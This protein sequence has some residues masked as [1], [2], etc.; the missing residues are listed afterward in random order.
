[1][2]RVIAAAG[3]LL[4]VAA[5][6]ASCGGASLRSTALKDARQY[7][8]ASNAQV[9]SLETVQLEGGARHAVAR[10]RGRFH[11]VP[12]CPAPVGNF[13]SRCHPFWTRYAMLELS[14][15]RPDIAG[16]WTTSRREETQ[17]AAARRNSLLGIFPDF[18]NLLVRCTIPGS[19]GGTVAGTCE[20]DG[21][22]SGRI[23]FREHWPL[24][25]PAGRRHTATWIATLSR[26][27]HPLTVRHS[28]DLPPQLWKSAAQPPV[29]RLSVTRARRELEYLRIFPQFPGTSACSIP[30]GGLRS[31][32]L[33]G[34]CTTRILPPDGNRPI[35]AFVERWHGQGRTL[36]GG[37]IVTLRHDD[38]VLT[39]R[40]TGSNPPQSWR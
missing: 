17:I 18:T 38:R 26:A 3:L 9:L 24:S 37:W 32:V 22:R 11:F 15:G 14:L 13:H 21:A 8:D 7:L 4:A 10:L 31:H 5:L 20:T 40:S 30:A 25:Q 36:T 29:P 12:N 23:V 33:R 2:T 16:Y 28:G 6:A 27:G 39:V 1:M 34:T 35:L 19:W